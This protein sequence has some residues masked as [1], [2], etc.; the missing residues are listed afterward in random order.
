MS[1]GKFDG[2]YNLVFLNAVGEMVVV[3]DPLGIRPSVLRQGRSAVCRG[4]RERGAV[5]FG[6]PGRR[7]SIRSCRGKWW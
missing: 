7:T 5:E 1:R 6:L 2:A 4:Q 3:R